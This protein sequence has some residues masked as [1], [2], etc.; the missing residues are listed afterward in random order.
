M[1]L[2]NYEVCLFLICIAYAAHVLEEYF[3]DWRSWASQTSK[4]ELRWSDF[5]LVNAAFFVF[6]FSCALIGSRS[7]AV[8]LALP[9][10]AVI[11]GVIFHALPTIVFRR[12]SPGLFTA[13]VFVCPSA[14]S[15]YAS[16][17]QAD[18]ISVNS[19]VISTVIGAAAM[20]TPVVIG[21]LSRQNKK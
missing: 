21:R 10:L 7:S 12:Y 1:Q 3:F 11:N 5:Y 4:T 18:L 9:A 19:I 16:A 6:A 20:F 14:V 2:P 17:S 8:S 15:A 13:I